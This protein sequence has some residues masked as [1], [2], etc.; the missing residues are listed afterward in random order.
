VADEKG[1]TGKSERGFWFPS[2]I[3]TASAKEMESFL[4]KHADAVFSGK[5]KI[6]YRKVNSAPI[7]LET[8]AIGESR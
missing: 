3:V 8:T 7:E 4:S 1:L 6:V 5:E 2:V